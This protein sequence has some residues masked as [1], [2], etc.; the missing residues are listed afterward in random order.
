METIVGLSLHEKLLLQI[1]DEVAGVAYNKIAL[2]IVEFM[3]SNAFNKQGISAKVST[4]Y[5]KTG[6]GF[7]YY[8]C[9]SITKDAL[10][11]GLGPSYYENDFRGKDDFVNQWRLVKRNFE[12]FLALGDDLPDIGVINFYKNGLSEEEIFQSMIITITWGK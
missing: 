5:I 12:K 3:H 8:T 1:E 4:E 9:F 10:F 2:N 6:I 7:K 11:A